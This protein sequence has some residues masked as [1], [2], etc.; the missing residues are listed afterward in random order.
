ML[1]VD[2]CPLSTLF[3]YP[4][5]YDQQHNN[6]AGGGLGSDLDS[7]RGTL[8]HDLGVLRGATGWLIEVVFDAYN[9]QTQKVS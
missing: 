7:A 2:Y 9:S 8:I 4:L 6:R 5:T 1:T 3:R